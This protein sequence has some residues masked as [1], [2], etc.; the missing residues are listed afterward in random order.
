L[1]PE[2]D[3]AETSFYRTEVTD[4]ERRSVKVRLRGG[5]WSALIATSKVHRNVGVIII[6][7]GDF[8]TEATLIDPLAKSALQFARLLLPDDYLRSVRVRSITELQQW[9]ATNHGAFTHVVLVGH[10]TK[11]GIE[12]GVG[13]V[14]DAASFSTCLMTPANAEKTFISLCCE[15]GRTPFAKAFSK[16]AFC[17]SYIAPYHSVHGAIASQFLQSFLSLHLLQGKSTAVAFKN[18]NLAIPGDFKFHHWRKAKLEPS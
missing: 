18:A 7:V 6:S 13:G 3:R 11:S 2:G 9:W 16:L 8:A 4:I 5:A 17:G 1:L 15:T 10:G 14:Q 12:F